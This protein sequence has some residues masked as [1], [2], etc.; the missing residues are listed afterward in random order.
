[1]KNTHKPSDGSMH[2][3][4]YMSCMY[5]NV[6]ISVFTLCLAKHYLYLLLVKHAQPLQVD[7]VG[8]SLSEGQAV[9]SDLFV[10]TVIGH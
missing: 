6:Y 7:H 2:V 8:Q 1:M 3:Y 10:Q 5:V 4:M 9:R